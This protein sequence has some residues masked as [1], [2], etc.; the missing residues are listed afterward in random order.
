ML[1]FTSTLRKNAIEK[2]RCVVV[3]FCEH[4][5]HLIILLALVLGFRL[6]TIVNFQPESYVKLNVLIPPPFLQ[7]S[8]PTDLKSAADINITPRD[9]SPKS[10]SPKRFQI[11]MRALLAGVKDQLKGPIP[12]PS[13]DTYVGAA[14]FVSN[15]IKQEAG[16][17]ADLFEQTSL[18]MALSNLYDLGDLHFS[19]YPSRAVDS[20]IDYLNSSTTHFKSL[21]YKIHASEG[22]GVDYI[23]HHLEKRA[24]ALIDIRQITPEIIN[25]V[26]RQNQ[27][28]LPNTNEVILLN[29]R[30]LTKD[31]QEYLTS[32]FLSLQ[33]IIDRWALNYAVQ[34]IDST[35]KCY[36]PA[37]LTVPYPTYDFN[38]NQFYER[39]GLVMGMAMT[40]S[41]LYPVS[42]L[43]RSI[44]EEKE[45]VSNILF[46][47]YCF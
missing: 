41:T 19:P 34:Q 47:K 29:S 32:G 35:A 6:S 17:D 5:S 1:Q 8:R 27:T 36:S 31:Y 23:L 28:T 10:N 21:N 3:T 7:V 18:G 46:I 14:K 45:S 33:D 20:L 42:R 44:V 43:V 22:E 11:N 2:R 24:L 9:V 25:Y 12:I 26:I 4:F 38:S 40:M 16:P 30:G 15:S 37:V 13:F 39:I